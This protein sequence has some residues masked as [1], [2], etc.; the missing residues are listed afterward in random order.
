MR[1]RLGHLLATCL[2]FIIGGVAESG[3]VHLKCE[4][5]ERRWTHVENLRYY[6][7]TVTS[8]E[9]NTT[10]FDTEHPFYASLLA[11]SSLRDHF[12]RRMEAHKLKFEQRDPLL[13][14]FLDGYRLSLLQSSDGT[15]H[16]VSGNAVDGI[17]GS[18]GDSKPHGPGIQGGAVPEPSTLVLMISSVAIGAAYLAGRQRGVTGLATRRNT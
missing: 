3:S 10:R 5:D 2:P 8:Y 7:R 13:W 12:L 17:P 16:S 1:F 11:N 4:T 18:H 14:R 6:D 9:D 15:P